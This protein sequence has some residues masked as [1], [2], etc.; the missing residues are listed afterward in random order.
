M[1]DDDKALMDALTDEERAAIGEE[2]LED[3]STE[4]EE[5]TDET[6]AAEAAAAD[7]SQPAAEEAP[8]EEA[9][10]ILPPLRAQAPDNAAE[11]MAQLA[12]EEEALAQKF[13]DGDI[14]AREYRD[15]IKKLSAQ[16]DEI[17]LKQFKAEIAD[18]MKQQAEVNAWHK[19]VQDFMTT[20][21]AHITKS[22]AAMVAF[23]DVVKK[24]TSDPANLK[25][26]NRAQLDKAYKLFMDDV[27]AAFGVQQQ[28]PA[29]TPAKAAAPKQQRNIPPTLA[30]VPAAEPE[31]FENSEFAA[32]DRLAATDPVA[33]EAAVAK[34]PEAKRAQYEAVL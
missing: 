3:S 10:P 32:L 5:T 27:N 26:S 20:T 9:D 18:D 8:A 31:S 23:D 6:T 16:E 7:E 28:K 12:A 34:M 2:G 24:V 19:E 25:L 29:E 11:V 22:N 1:N 14:T 13:D 33:Y 21:A 15:G 4:T 17:R 30:K